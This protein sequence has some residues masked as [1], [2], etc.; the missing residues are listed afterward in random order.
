MADTF[1]QTYVPGD[2][3]TLGDKMDAE[4]VTV[5]ANSVKRERVQIT[6]ANEFEIARVIDT[7]PLGTE[8][9]LAV[10]IVG[11]KGMSSAYGAAFPTIGVPLGIFD[12][13]NMVAPRGVVAPVPDFTLPGLLVTISGMLGNNT[14]IGATNPFALP[15]GGY[16]NRTPPSA[17]GLFGSLDLTTLG[18]LKVSI[19]EVAAGALLL[20]K[21][22]DG[23]SGA[24]DVGIATL[25]V[26]KD[27]LA[28][29][30]PAVADYTPIL[31]DSTGSMWV[32]LSTMAQVTGS[33]AH[34]GIDTQPPVKIGGFAS[35]A[36]RT[37]VDEG[38]RVDGSFDLQGRL[39]VAGVLSDGTLKVTE[40][41]PSGTPTY[42]VVAI[43]TTA[44]GIVIKAS[45]A[46]RR[47]I[48]VVNHGTAAV[49]IGFDT[50]LDAT[51]GILL[52]GIAGTSLTFFTTAQIRGITASGS[53]N[54]GYYE[55][56]LA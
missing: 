51:N 3:P 30:T 45:N 41:S 32:T 17:D 54:V 28:T 14:S 26:R 46:N 20:G 22:I 55:E 40:G 2:P 53:V 56:V 15:V 42:G 38:D 1:I 18:H 16:R 39:R 35:A 6:G 19:A 21:A 43:D 48:T 12:G 9:S 36:L 29:L 10:R 44:T 52:P 8:M 50:S 37:A 49:F 23:A 7:A 11:Q 34:G 5:G 27:T 25:A 47:R 33:V 4:L 13:T 31:V 24:T